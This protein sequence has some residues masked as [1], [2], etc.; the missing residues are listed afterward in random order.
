MAVRQI[1]RYLL[2]TKDKGIILDPKDQE[3]I[4]WC[5]ADFCGN[6]NPDTAITDAVTAKS[7][8]GYAITYASCPIFW[9]S[10]MQTEVTLS[11]T[12]AEYV[13]LSQ[14]LRDVIPLMRIV[15]EIRQR[16]D[17][18]IAA[19]PMVRCTVFEDNSGAME[20]ANV[21]KMRPRTKHINNKYHHFREHVRNKTISIL[22]V[23]TKDQVADY[24]TKPLPKEI[25]QKHRLALQNW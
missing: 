16:F 5:D 17:A 3:F 2:G 4:V 20:M 12:E 13:S 24:L 8:S 1:V 6:W 7:R 19:K 11:T 22:A 9:A 25:F 23:D 21:P 15:D 14:S 10:K 18:G